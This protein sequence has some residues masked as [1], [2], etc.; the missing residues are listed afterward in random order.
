MGIADSPKSSRHNPP[1]NPDNPSPPPRLNLPSRRSNPDPP[2]PLDPLALPSNQN[3]PN[4]PLPLSALQHPHAPS[5]LHPINSPPPNRILPSQITLSAPTLHSTTPSLNNPLLECRGHSAG[6]KF[7]AA[8]VG[9]EGFRK[10]RRGLVWGGRLMQESWAGWER[11][12]RCGDGR[13]DEARR[14]RSV[15]QIRGS[16]GVSERRSRRR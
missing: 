1:I 13:G 16:G 7:C 5:P 2:P 15:L 14:R 10:R 6:D 9:G 12:G 8:A 4:L 3:Q 11:L